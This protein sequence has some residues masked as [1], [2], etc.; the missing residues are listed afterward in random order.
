MKI[1]MVLEFLALVMM[2][3]IQHVISIG[4]PVVT[5]NIS[6]F[7]YLISRYSNQAYQY[8]TC[9]VEHLNPNQQQYLNFTHDIPFDS[10]SVVEDLIK[11]WT[12]NETDCVFSKDAP[13]VLVDFSIGYSYS[14]QYEEQF[15]VPFDWASPARYSTEYLLGKI[16]GKSLQLYATKP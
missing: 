13:G 7:H 15:F 11:L 2:I 8:V 5:R 1:T 10:D 9:L 4:T 6:S 14:T 12:T 3:A 16:I